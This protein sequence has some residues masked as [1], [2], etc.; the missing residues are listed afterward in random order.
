MFGLRVFEIMPNRVTPTINAK[1]GF[2][3]IMI[4]AVF[5]PRS[6]RS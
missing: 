4:T 5:Y 6:E 2:D 3:K 1:S